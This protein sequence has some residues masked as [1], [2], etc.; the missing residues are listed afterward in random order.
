MFSLEKDGLCAELLAI[1]SYSVCLNDGANLFWTVVKGSACTNWFKLQEKRFQFNV[2][3]CF[4][5]VGAV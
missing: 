4:L 5:T 1:F 3:T 2:K